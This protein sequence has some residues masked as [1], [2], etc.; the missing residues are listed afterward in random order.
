MGTLIISYSG[1]IIF[2][3]FKIWNVLRQFLYC[4]NSTRMYQHIQNLFLL[5]QLFVRFFVCS[6]KWST[7]FCYCWCHDYYKYKAFLI[8]LSDNLSYQCQSLQLFHLLSKCLWSKSNSC[9]VVYLT[10]DSIMKHWNAISL[11]QPRALPATV[12]NVTSVSINVIW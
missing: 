4:Y 7:T 6:W 10:T 5:V 11:C 1:L 12:T 8:V 3:S 2:T 9:Y